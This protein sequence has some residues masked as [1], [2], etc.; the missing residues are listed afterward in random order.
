MT[1]APP[2]DHSHGN[3]PVP[4]PTRC[5]GTLRSTGPPGGTS[6]THLRPLSP[7]PTKRAGAQRLVQRVRVLHHPLPVGAAAA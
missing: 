2:S 7:P 1:A 6:R 3:H 5:R 4:E